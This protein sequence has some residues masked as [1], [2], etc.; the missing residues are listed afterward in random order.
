ML[1][2]S[3]LIPTFSTPARDSQFT[4]RLISTN[5]AGNAP[6][7]S[8]KGEATFLACASVLRSNTRLC[9]ACSCVQLISTRSNG[10]GQLYPVKKTK[11]KY[12]EESNEQQVTLRTRL[13]AEPDAN[14]RQRFFAPEWDFIL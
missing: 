3:F 9:S 6:N 10:R 4:G 8:H 1:V 12:W 11:T 5:R 14:E 2:I 7:P 13:K